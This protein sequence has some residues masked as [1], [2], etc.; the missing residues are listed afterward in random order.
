MK[1]NLP[2]ILLALAFGFI[3][4]FSVSRLI[5]I[6]LEYRQGEASYEELTQYVSTPTP[7]ADTQTADP[8]PQ[9]SPDNTV[10][11]EIDFKAL[12]AI[13]DDVVGWIYLE[14]TKVNYPI[15]L[16]EDNFYYLNRLYDGT[17]NG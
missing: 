3:A 9:V 1:K 13:N 7:N 14:G 12:Q 10:W 15:V 6:Y 11:P 8:V 16:G 4:L 2:L 5:G 17:G